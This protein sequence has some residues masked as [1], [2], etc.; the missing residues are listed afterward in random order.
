MRD[1]ADDYV[2]DPSGGFTDTF[3][4]ALAYIYPDTIF[5][6]YPEPSTPAY[7]RA[8]SLSECS[9]AGVWVRPSS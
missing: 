5:I 3:S 9:R 4:C 6:A 2:N 7:S 1:P 8:V